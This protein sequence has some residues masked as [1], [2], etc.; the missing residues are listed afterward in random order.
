M[1][2]L[3]PLKP[4]DQKDNDAVEW[5]EWSGWFKVEMDKLK[6]NANQRKE[7]E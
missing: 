4:I 3:I 7:R 2:K 5:R 1:M 6:P